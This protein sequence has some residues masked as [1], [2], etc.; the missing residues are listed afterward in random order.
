[1][2]ARLFVHALAQIVCGLN[3]LHTLEPFPVG[4]LDLKPGNV[5]LTACGSAKLT[6]FGLAAEL[7]GQVGLCGTE[8]YRPP[9]VCGKHRSCTLRAA[10]D[11]WAFAC[12]M[13]CVLAWGGDPY[14]LFPGTGKEVDE[15]V[16]KGELR[17]HVSEP[18]E[19]TRICMGCSDELHWQRWSSGQACR[20]LDTYMR[21][22]S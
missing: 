1:M 13:V 5:L 14:P 9:E 12:I 2:C 4:H 16:R 19:L 6:D 21:T 10:A 18:D 20:A 7:K 3:Y 17:P 22:L 11:V 15:A 8:G